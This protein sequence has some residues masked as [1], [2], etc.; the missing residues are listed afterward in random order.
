[1]TLARAIRR[2]MLR[3]PKPAALFSAPLQRLQG[4]KDVEEFLEDRDKTVGPLRPGCGSTVTWAP[5]LEGRAADVVVVFLHGFSASPHEVFPVDTRVAAGLSAHL[6]RFRLSGHGLSPQE[7]SAVGLRDGTR[8]LYQADVATAHEL[9]KLLGRLVVF[10]G[11][12]TGGT[13]ALWA[14]TQP[15]AN[16]SALVLISP[17]FEIFAFGRVGWAVGSWLFTVLP[18]RIRVRLMELVAGREFSCRMETDEQRRV[19]TATWPTA[20]LLNLIELYVALSLCF[21]RR[22]FRVPVLTLASP[23]DDVVSFEATKEQVGSLPTGQFETVAGLSGAAAHS[24]A[25]D[26]YAP[27]K[28]DWCVERITGF[29]TAVLGK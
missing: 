19:W 4:P 5:G 25:G 27:G 28:T 9:A 2:R 18:Y 10:M 15:W 24:L 13:L 22:E 26:F 16:I 17:G 12:S 8:C 20:A 3:V 1:M 14:A 23:D 21:D 7:R 11:M 6:L 29:L